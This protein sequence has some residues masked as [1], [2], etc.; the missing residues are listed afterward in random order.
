MSWYGLVGT[1]V[2]DNQMTTR[3]LR[4]S[5]ATYNRLLRSSLFY[6]LG[7]L[8]RSALISDQDNSF[9]RKLSYAPSSL[10]G[11][12]GPG[13]GGIRE[14]IHH[15]DWQLNAQLINY[16][17]STKARYSPREINVSGTHGINEVIGNTIYTTEENG[18]VML[19]VEVSHTN[20]SGQLH[21]H[22]LPIIYLREL[23]A[24][25]CDEI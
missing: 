13:G 25:W 18:K 3:T 14:S 24:A 16:Y 23:C 5:A 19:L 21:T 11:P 12:Q 22:Y 8:Q 17:H 20:S 7:W 1:F 4:V 2:I 6:L 9:K 10:S 15:L